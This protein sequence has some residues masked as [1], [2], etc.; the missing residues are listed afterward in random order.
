MNF[1]KVGVR[2]K[3]V[4]VASLDWFVY[5]ASRVPWFCGWDFV[6]LTPQLWRLFWARLGAG[7]NRVLFPG[8]CCGR[9]SGH[10]PLSAS[11]CPLALQNPRVIIKGVWISSSSRER[12]RGW[13]LRTSP[14]PAGPGHEANLWKMWLKLTA[15][16]RTTVLF[17]PAC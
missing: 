17:A 7:T 5:V 2:P 3:S 8:M 9:F 6:P 13:R 16:L 15:C 11:R 1:S 10:C 14:V 12:D 4:N